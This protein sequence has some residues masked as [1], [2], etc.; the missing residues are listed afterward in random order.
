MKIDKSE[1]EKM[2][3][4]H[5]ELLEPGIA[6]QLTHKMIEQATSQAIEHQIQTRRLMTAVAILQGA[7]A[8]GRVSFGID[9]KYHISACKKAI[10]YADTLIEEMEKSDAM[11][12]L[13]NKLDVAEKE[14]ERIC[15]TVKV[16]CPSCKYEGHIKVAGHIWQEGLA[17]MYCD[18]CR[19][20]IMQEDMIIVPDESSV[21]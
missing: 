19:C 7:L 9:D 15:F 11:D 12:R 2:F 18:N 6:E 21:E 20:H 8:S 3:D 14:I 13:G 10:R 4:K 17:A 5:P 1:L 16:T